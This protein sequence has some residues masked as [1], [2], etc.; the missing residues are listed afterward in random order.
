MGDIESPPASAEG[1]GG[2]IRRRI[3]RHDAEAAVA[4]SDEAGWNQT[5]E[6]WRFMLTHG[7]A[8]GL[9]EPG[10]GWA[11]SSLVLPQARGLAWISM[12]LVSG[13][14]RR[15]GLGTAL[16]KQ[17]VDDVR[18]SG[19]VAGLDATELGRP[20]YLPHGFSDVYATSRWRVDPEPAGEDR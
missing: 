11:A 9:W 8:T 6:D 18:A 2:L 1:L 19:A 15:K 12:L 14:H 16:L 20:V 17:C 7:C 10:V 4:L 13:R 3:E 5:I